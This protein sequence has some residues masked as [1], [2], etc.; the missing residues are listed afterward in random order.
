MISLRIFL[1][2]SMVLFLCNC[3]S[4]ETEWDQA[5]SD[6]HSGTTSA[7]Y[8]PWQGEWKTKTNGHTGDLRAIVKPAS[9]EGSYTFRYHATWGLIFQG[10]YSVTFPG[11]K[12][13]GAYVIEGK[14]SLGPFG[15]F[16]H[17]ATVNSNSFKASYSNENG[18]LGAFTLSRP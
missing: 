1:A 13:G 14:K 3:S 8:G 17:K 2:S 9:H 16:G 5:V 12:Q 11:E 10:T 18:D 4:F 15:T 6:Y 7:P